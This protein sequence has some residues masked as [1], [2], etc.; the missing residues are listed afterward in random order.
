MNQSAI[1]E[2]AAKIGDENFVKKNQDMSE[3]WVIEQHKR[4]EDIRRK[5]CERQMA[6]KVVR[7]IEAA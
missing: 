1:A 7:E 2:K 4:T 6:A 5:S 3:T